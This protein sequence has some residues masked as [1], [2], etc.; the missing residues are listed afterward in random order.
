MLSGAGLLGETILSGHLRVVL[1]TSKEGSYNDDLDRIGG[2]KLRTLMMAPLV[3]VN[4]DVV[5]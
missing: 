2:A 4:G 5:Q 3:T 1:N